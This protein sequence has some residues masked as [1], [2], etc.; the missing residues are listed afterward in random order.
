MSNTAKVTEDETDYEHNWKDKI[1]GKG[2]RSRWGEPM[3]KEEG[4]F[5]TETSVDSSLSGGLM[6][7]L[8]P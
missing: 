8:S 2:K 3:T 6:S 7:L 5:H 4:N 1:K